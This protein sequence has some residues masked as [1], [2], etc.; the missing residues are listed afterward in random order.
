MTSRR[1]RAP[2]VLAYATV[3]AT[4]FAAAACH[5][6]KQADVLAQDSSLAHDLALANHDTTSQPQLKDIP[7][8]PPPAPAPSAPAPRPK[9]HPAPRPTPSHRP[10]PPPPPPPT[11]PTV[12]PSGNTVVTNSVPNNNTEGRVGTI[13]AGSY[14]S[15]LAGQRV[16]TN[17]NT[18]GDRF[19]ATLSSA[20]SGSNG[21][22]IPAGATAVVEVTSLKRSDQA[23]DNMG[24]GLVVRSVTF[25]GKTY[26][27]DGQIAS[28]QVEQVKASDNHDAA[29]VLGG[30]A[31]GA[32]LGRIFSGKSKTKGTVI[33][34]AGGAAA[35]AVLA[36]QTEHYDA[37]I[38]S[39]GRISLKLDEPL[40]IQA[41]PSYTPPP[42]NPGAGDN[43]I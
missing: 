42:A 11:R 24:I 43:S 10:S 25:G 23:G 16:C 39:G 3:C 31:V 19:T 1:S 27:V 28:A 14:L 30:A 36:H 32:I 22:I 7:A 26:P 21:V 13:G 8:T 6:D 38:P 5:K 15:L 12:T 41:T 40:T 29:K 9:P 2:I 17:T 4:L 20:V 35:G 18:V 34:A 33:G 37:C